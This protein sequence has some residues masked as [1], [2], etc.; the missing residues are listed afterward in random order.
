MKKKEIKQEPALLTMEDFPLQM[1]C[2]VTLKE[3]QNYAITSSAEERKKVKNKTLLTSA[4][5]LLSGIF[6]IYRGVTSTWVYK[7]WLTILG[8]LC[9]GYAILD[10]FYQFILFG[11]VLKRQIAKEFKQD[12]RLGRD[13][14]FCF[15]EDRMVSF[16]KGSHQGTFYY[17]EVAEQEDCGDI[18]LLKLKN[19]KVM[20]FPKRVIAAADPQIQQI[21][22]G[23]GK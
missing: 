11:T 20:V 16:Y 3:Y 15:A 1:N 18:Q 10:V 21:I 2:Q 19:G 17:D 5:F 4:L 12:E 8:V 14:T 23:L 7:D 13:M 9:A 22:H 6:I